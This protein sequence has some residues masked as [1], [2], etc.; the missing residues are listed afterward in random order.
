MKK[1]FSNAARVKQ[2]SKQL[3]GDE[4]FY[5]A[6]GEVVNK[7]IQKESL[8]LQTQLLSQILK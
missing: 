6:F 8:T 5:N 1:R 2:N 3:V 7:L 4:I